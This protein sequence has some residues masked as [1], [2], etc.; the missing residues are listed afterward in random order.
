M[1][2]ED[3]IAEINQ[4][5]FLKEFSFSKN[6]FTPHQSSELQFSD[7]VIWLD[8]LLITF[9]IKERNASHA[10]SEETEISWFKD[11]VIGKATRQIRDTLDY[12]TKYQK[13]RI[14]NGRGHSFNVV[15][16]SIKEKIH[17]A[18]Y[19]PHELL[20]NEFKRKKFHYSKTAGFIHL[21]SADDYEGICRTLITIHELNEYLKFREKLCK[22][23]G[24]KANSL[25]E[26]AIIGQFLYGDFETEPDINFVRYLAA[27]IQEVERFDLLSIFQNFAEHITTAINP[28]EYYQILKELAKLKRDELIEFKIRFDLCLEKSRQDKFELP[29]RITIPRTGCGFVFVVTPK[30]QRK[31]ISTGIEN[32]TYAHK[33][34]QKLSKCVGVAFFFDGQ[35]YDILWCYLEEKWEYDEK[36]EK[37]L[38]ESFPFREVKEESKIRYKFNTNI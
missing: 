22:K 4:G 38:R 3:Q 14:R 10:L 13:I 16:E 23:F 1:K 25:P 29:Y 26:Q 35:E 12:L 33:Y 20:P 7:H 6:E 17:I 18:L 36:M 37:K 30:E 9:Q 27:L 5:F 8:D 31:Y 19:K 11:K 32:Y 21:L 34:D 24:T 15:S 28:H 2:L